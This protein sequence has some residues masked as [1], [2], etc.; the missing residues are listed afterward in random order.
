MMMTMM[1]QFKQRSELFEE[2]PNIYTKVKEGRKEGNV[3]LNDAFNTFYLRLYG[4]R[5]GK[6]PLR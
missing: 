1:N 3:F 2:W 4:V 6:E 5:H